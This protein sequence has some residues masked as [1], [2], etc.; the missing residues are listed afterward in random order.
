MN[1]QP[2]HCSPLVRALRP[3][4]YR[5]A[6][7]LF[8]SAMHAP[9]V[10]DDQWPLLAR[11]IAPRE[12]FGVFMGAQLAGICQAIPTRLTV[13]GGGTVRASA[14]GRFAMRPDHTRKGAGTALMA[15]YLGTTTAPVIILRASEGGIYRH[16]GFGVSTSA[17]NVVVNR[18][19]A[20]LTADVADAGRVRMMPA[21]DAGPLTSDVYRRTPRRPGMVDRADYFD[22]LLRFEAQTSP[23][24]LWVAVHT[25]PG[26]NDGFALYLVR[27]TSRIGETPRTVL[28]VADMHYHT[29]DAWTGLWRYLLGVDLVD[30]ISLLQRP[31][32][33][34]TAWLFTDPRSCRLQTDSDETWLRITDVATAL[35]A[36]TMVGD[37]P[38][39]AEISDALLP[40]NSGRY[41]L[42][43][44]GTHR[45]SLPAQ[46]SLD[47]ST[48]ASL[49]LGRIRPSAL[50]AVGRITVHAGGE[51]LEIADRLF[52]APSPPWC[53]T[54]V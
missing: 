7:D 44:R 54:G 10:T 46:L 8:Q 42:S 5:D 36:R 38:L 4:E 2:D 15:T 50:A 18:H 53:G 3:S 51:T 9:L 43:A 35:T 31:S 16:F 13:P 34:P 45:T 14:I 25:G 33:E 1:N 22:D 28:T 6:V 12:A 37:E 26:G 29:A 24:P 39:V 41:S 23:S 20:V 47:I 40:R 21:Q 49:Y 32:D 52:S 27:E 30:E 17:G 48:L 19:Q 11:T